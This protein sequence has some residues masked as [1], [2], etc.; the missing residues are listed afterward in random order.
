[1]DNYSQL[2][3]W[4]PNDTPLLLNAVS[5]LAPHPGKNEGIEFIHR[6]VAASTDS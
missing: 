2:A 4:L 5:D 1:M 3:T 6:E